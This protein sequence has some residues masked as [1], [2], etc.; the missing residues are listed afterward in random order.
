MFA[1]LLLAL[2]A[3]GEAWAGGKSVT[4][5]EVDLKREQVDLVIQALP[6]MKFQVGDEVVNERTLRALLHRERRQRNIQYIM[7]DGKDATVGH[8]LVAAQI[9]KKMRLTLVSETE[10]GF[11]TVTVAD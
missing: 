11:R 10:G 4:S 2:L 6:D 5:Q 9:A 7:L 3:P 1:L 8:V